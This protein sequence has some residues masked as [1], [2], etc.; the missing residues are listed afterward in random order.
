MHKRTALCAWEDCLVNLLCDFLIV[1]KDKTATWTAKCLVSCS[2]YNV[3]VWN[4]RSVL[5]CS[6]KSRNVGD[7]SEQDV[8]P[9]IDR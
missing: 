7:V 6:N 5:A 4:R 3:S 8:H 9:T 1:C 2:C